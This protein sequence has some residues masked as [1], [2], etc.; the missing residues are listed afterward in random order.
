MPATTALRR[1]ISA[2]LFALAPVALLATSPVEAQEAQESYSDAQLDAFASAALA[3]SALRE[4]FSGQLDSAEGEDERQQVI[5]AANQR[6]METIEAAEGVT[7]DSY[8]SIA[9]AAGEDDELNARIMD[10]I[11]A[12]QSE[13]G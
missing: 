12:Q 1:T 2:A 9:E 4:E 5:E 3:V 7:V 6:I 8:I 13:D 11:E 10:R